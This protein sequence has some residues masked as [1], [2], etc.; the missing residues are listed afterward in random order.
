VGPIYSKSNASNSQEKLK[1]AYENSLKVATKAKFKSVAFPSISTGVYGYPMKDATNIAIQTVGQYL[2]S[3]EGSQLERVIFCVFS[4]KDY[5]VYAS[6][7][8]DHFSA[9]DD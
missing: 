4:K 6:I 5:D 2:E 9:K 3:S 1:S 7:L 8:P